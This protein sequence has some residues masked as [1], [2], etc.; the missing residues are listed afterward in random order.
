MKC[1]VSVMTIRNFEKPA[2][3]R[4]ERTGETSQITVRNKSLKTLLKCW[5]Y[6]VSSFKYTTLSSSS[7]NKVSSTS[8]STVI[9][10]YL[11]GYRCRYRENFRIFSEIKSS[12]ANLATGVKFYHSNLDYKAELRRTITVGFET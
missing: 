4:T 10:K 6:Y 12:Y 9:N 2:I 7:S 1:D 11:T 3:P 8:T 5:A